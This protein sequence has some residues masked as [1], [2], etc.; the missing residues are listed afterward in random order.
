M[1][2]SAF[3]LNT[4]RPGHNAESSAKGTSFGNKRAIKTGADAKKVRK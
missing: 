3:M 1:I 2:Q 4:E